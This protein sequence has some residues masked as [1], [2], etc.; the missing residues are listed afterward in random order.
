M[1]LFVYT[2]LMYC[3]IMIQIITER[4]NQDDCKEHGWILDGFPRTEAQAESL[5]SRGITAGM[6]HNLEVQTENE[7]TER[8]A[9]IDL[10]K[11]LFVQFKTV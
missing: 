8:T 4:L 1:R 6:I 9:T 5:V 3:S 7:W 11:C 10:R 2:I